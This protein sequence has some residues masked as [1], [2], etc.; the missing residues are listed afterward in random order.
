MPEPEMLHRV[1]DF[2]R[3]DAWVIDGNYAFV[4]DVI[5]SRATHIV[6]LDYS[7]WVVMFRIV[8]RT[9]SRM[10][11]RKRLWNGNREDWRFLFKLDPEENV[12]L[13]AWQTYAKRRSDFD[14]LVSPMP[15]EI[16]VLRFNKPREATSWLSE[17]ADRD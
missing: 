10:I 3:G 13:W 14:A 17:R 4:R 12:I 11:F 9:L 7:R 16:E 8:R 5:L 6:M 15:S 2:C 1:E